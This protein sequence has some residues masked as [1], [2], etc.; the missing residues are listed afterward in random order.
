MSSIIADLFVVVVDLPAN[1]A[2]PQFPQPLKERQNELISKVT[3]C[4]EI[5]FP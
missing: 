1:L 4:F 3:S 5:L 2:V